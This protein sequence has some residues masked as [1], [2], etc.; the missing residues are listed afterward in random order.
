MNANRD[1]E[2]E[3]E[4]LL[5]F[6]DEEIDESL[7]RSLALVPETPRKRQTVVVATSTEGT[8]HACEE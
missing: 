6:I 7:R 8:G 1:I 5:R 2:R 3:R 4:D